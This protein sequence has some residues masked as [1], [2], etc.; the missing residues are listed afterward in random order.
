M[1]QLSAMQPWRSFCVLRW[2]ENMEEATRRLK[3]NLLHF[4]ALL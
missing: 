1:P 3:R 4:Q 2:P